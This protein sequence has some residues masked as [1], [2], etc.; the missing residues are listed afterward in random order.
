MGV[1]DWSAQSVTV[2]TAENK[3][4]LKI[5]KGSGFAEPFC[6][7]L[8]IIFTHISPSPGKRGILKGP[9]ALQHPG[10]SAVSHGLLLPHHRTPGS[11]CDA[12]QQRKR[13]WSAEGPRVCHRCTANTNEEPNSGSYHPKSAGQIKPV[14]MEDQC[15]P[16]AL[17]SFAGIEYQQWPN[18]SPVKR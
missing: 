14:T 12:A 16:P 10:K 3:L 13:L 8:V 11:G 5:D 9:L 1:G 15:F 4:T 18:S 17:L 2:K 6:K 7:G